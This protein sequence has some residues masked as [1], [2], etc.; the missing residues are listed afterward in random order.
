MVPKVNKNKYK[1]YKLKND[2]K[3]L[4]IQDET[5]E[6]GYAALDNQVG[7]WN[8]PSD[9]PGLA[10]FLEHMIFLA[11]DPENPLDDFLADNGG[12]SNAYTSDDNTNYFFDV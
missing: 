3:V 5:A 6:F 12:G 11:G 1:Y 10:H 8:E 2:L 4:L 9:W 7:S